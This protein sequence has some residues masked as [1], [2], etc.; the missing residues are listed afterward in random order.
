M[1]KTSK[2]TCSRGHRYSESG[3]CHICWPGSKKKKLAAKKNAYTNRHANGSL[4]A[5]G[6]MADGKMDGS[7]KWFRQDGSV[8]RTGSFSGGKQTGKWTTYDKKGRIVKV[9]NF[10]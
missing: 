4:W 5:K 8:M 1:K 6:F 7:W 10:K 9:T 2:K 3:R